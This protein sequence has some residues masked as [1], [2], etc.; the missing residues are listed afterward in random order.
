M[1]STIRAN[2]KTKEAA[3]SFNTAD[4]IDYEKNISC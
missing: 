1:P 2:L 4:K 3:S